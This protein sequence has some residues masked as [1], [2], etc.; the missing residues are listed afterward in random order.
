MPCSPDGGV[1]RFLVQCGMESCHRSFRAHCGDVASCSAGLHVWIHCQSEFVCHWERVF[2][3][4]SNSHLRV[5]G[6]I[7]WYF[8]NWS[9]CPC[10]SWLRDSHKLHHCSK[11]KSIMLTIHLFWWFSVEPTSCFRAPIPWRIVLS[12]FGPIQSYLDVGIR[13][14]QTV[15]RYGRLNWVYT[16]VC[17]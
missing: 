17:F 7:D 3:S 14:P 8:S 5:C 10:L 9:S 12:W 11:M 4:M 13:P 16:G 6:T 15:S 2:R 1:I